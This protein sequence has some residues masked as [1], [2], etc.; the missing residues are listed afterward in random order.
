MADPGAKRA[1]LRYRLYGKIIDTTGSVIYALIPWVG[2]IC[3]A[4]YVHSS[5]KS[6]AGQ[7]TLASI[8]IRFLADF[9]ISEAL[10][11]IFGACGVGYGFM[12]RKLRKD[13]VERMA[14]RIKE[15]EKQIDVRRSS[16][17][18]TPRGETRP[19]DKR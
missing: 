16:S 8:G 15:L 3:V 17:R 19:E 4:Y 12:N 11:Y 10:A 14:K 6:L 9:R 2:V 13:N 18:L 5:I 7:R 1:E